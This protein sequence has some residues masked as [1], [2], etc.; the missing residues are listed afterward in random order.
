MRRADL[1]KKYYKNPQHDYEIEET[2]SSTS[3]PLDICWVM[4]GRNRG[5][6]YEISS[7]LLA[8]AWYDSK[9]FGYIRRNDAT[10]YDVEQ[11]FADKTDFIR[12][13]TDR[14]ATGITKYKGKL[15][16]YRWDITDEDAKKVYVKEAGNFF[17][18]SRQASYKSLQYP[19]IFNLLFEEVL[20]DGSYLSAEPE[21]LMNLYSTIRRGKQGFR[22]WLVNNLVTAVNPY[23]Q[24]WGLNLSQLKPN[25]IKLVKLYL[26][27]YK[28]D[29]EEDYL[30][31]ACHY[32]K[33]KGDLTKEDLKKNAKNRIKTGI[34]SNKWDELT[35]YNS[36]PIRI[37]KQFPIL[38]VVLFE[39]D[40]M[41]FQANILEVPNNLMDYV[42]N[43]TEEEPVA[44]S[45]STIPILY[46]RRKTTEPHYGTRLF[47]N[48]SE[49]LD[50]YTTR[51]YVVEYT[52]DEAVETLLKRGW[53]VGADNLTLNDFYKCFNNL[54]QM[55][56]K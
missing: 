30:Y 15:W 21:K 35:L 56:Y 38:D 51:G 50:E 2:L 47:T 49:R 29:G 46:V 42:L 53:I 5:K 8:D 37:M 36:I 1:F 11:Y 25:D 3:E 9:Q 12:D 7:Q 28:E 44:F 55:R 20:T 22:M 52:I 41:M 45:P 34:A 18:L 24:S 13:M 26:G 32:L 17:A 43:N 40:D 39:Y 31:I 4:S 54:R 27:S 33:D 14:E 6:S 23:S 48:N 10:S 19:M 16:F